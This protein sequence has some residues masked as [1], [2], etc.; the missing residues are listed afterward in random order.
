MKIKITK[1]ISFSLMI[2]GFSC[3]GFAQ[4]EPQFTQYMFNRLSYN[5]AYAG[6]SGSIC[7]S[8]MYRNQWLGLHLDAP[9]PDVEAGSTPVNYLLHFDTPVKVLH[10]GIGLQLEAENIGYHS[11]V[12]GAFDYAFRIYWGPGNLAA[13]IEGNFF[14]TSLD[15]AQLRGWSDLSGDYNNP[16]SASGDPLLNGDKNSSDFLF[17]LST[18]IY[19]QVPG[20]YYFGISLKNILAAKSEVLH[21]MNARNIYLMGGYEYTIPA[22]PSFKLKPSALIKTADFSTFQVDV[23]CL[24]DY[25]NLFFGGVTYR[26]QDAV[27]V[28]GGFNWDHLRVGLSYDL[29]TSRIGTFKPGLSA[30][31]LELYLRYCFRVIIPPK[32]PSVY[33]NT[34]YLF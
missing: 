11:A 34:R 13:A 30:G 1:I 32:P 31:T 21:M 22:N 23:S 24:L 29:T 27:A 28:L 17:D 12:R 19:Y 7:L 18:G 4:Q 6:S 3:V 2:L 26:F 9:T 25:Q 16:Y 5:P 8:L 10:G 14:N 33:R 15:Y 20:S